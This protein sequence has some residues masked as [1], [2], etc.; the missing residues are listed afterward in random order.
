MLAS[1]LSLLALHNLSFPAA[2]GP[3]VLPLPA[4]ISAYAEK[5]GTSVRPQLGAKSSLSID[6]ETGKV[7]YEEN[8][9]SELPMASLTKLMT[10]LVILENHSLDEVVDIDPRATQVEPAKIFLLAHEKITVRDLVRSIVV[11]SANDSALALAYYDSGD[12]DTFVTKMNTRARQLGMLGTSFQNPIGFD[13][14]QQYSTADDLAILA[15]K[16]YKIPIVQNTAVLTKATVSSVDQKET[17]DLES[18]NELL[19]SYLKVFGLKTGTTDAAGQC[20]ISI[21]ESPSGHKIMNIML[22]SPSRFNEAKLLS[23]W[24]FDNYSWI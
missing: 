14:P 8:S 12:L 19:N 16:V 17:H 20:L 15:R 21:V 13:D 24:I 6:L 7:L 9:S 2:A 23:Q 11:K 3:A 4:E 18:T 22:N 1:L 10:L 5:T